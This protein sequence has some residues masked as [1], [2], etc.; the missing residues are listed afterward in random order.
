MFDPM[1]YASC[2]ALFLAHDIVLREEQYA[3]L[4]RYAALLQNESAVQNVTAVTALGEIWTRHFLDS[5]YLLRFLPTDAATVIDIGT[6]GGMPGIPLAILCPQHHVTLLDS[7]LRKISFCQSVIS[8][9]QLQSHVTA[10]C[11]RAEELAKLP[12][13]R[14]Q[15]DIAVSRAMASGT[16][17]SE[18]AI[19]MLR[20]GG[21]L[22][23]MKGR[24]YDPAFERF[25][26]AVDALGAEIHMTHRYALNGEEK[27]LVQV[28]KSVE[29][30][31]QYP[32]RFAKIKRNPL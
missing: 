1:N 6:G 8:D 2:C 21:S 15:F 9:L 22:L 11:G 27:Y 16:M 10:V 24:N 19:P 28:K 3:M 20:I 29:T 25:A 12:D 5:A 7:E 14:A 32:R 31:A 26:E 17:L 23:A 13:Y 30:P 4:L 18:L